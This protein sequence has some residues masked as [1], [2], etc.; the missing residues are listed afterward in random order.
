MLIICFQQFMQKMGEFVTAEMWTDIVETF[1]LCFDLCNPGSQLVEQVDS[2]I[3]LHDTKSS[4]ASE[5]HKES[6]RKRITE[7]EAALDT[8]LSNCLVQL[9]VVNTLKEALDTSYDKLSVQDSE[10]M[11]ATLQRSFDQS[12][13]VTSTFNNCVKMQRVD[14]MAGLQLF[15]GSVQQEYRSLAAVLTLKFYSYFSPKDG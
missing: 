8:I 4:D 9:F 3:A 13:A 7:N 11:L 5:G 1:C 15:R 2:F 14:Q 10:R 6:F 12:N